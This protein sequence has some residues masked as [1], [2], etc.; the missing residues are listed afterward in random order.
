MPCNLVH[1]C[2]P[3]AVLTHPTLGPVRADGKLVET[4][5]MLALAEPLS[6]KG[7]VATVDVMTAQLSTAETLVTAVAAA[8]CR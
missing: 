3:S 2:P 5:V 8:F 7:N 6:I 4:T 1:Q